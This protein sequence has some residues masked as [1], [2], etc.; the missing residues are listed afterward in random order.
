MYNDRGPADVRRV[1]TGKDA[2]L[3]NESGALLATVDTFTAQVNVTNA[4][5]QPLGDTQSHENLSSYSVSLNITQC[6]IE[7]DEFIQDMFTM[8]SV[9]Q[10]VM[11]TFQ[12]V[13]KGRNGSEQRMI[14]LKKIS[15]SRKGKIIFSFRVHPLKD[16]ELVKCRRQNLKNRGKRNEELNSSRYASQV[17]YMATLDEDRAKIWDNKGALDKLNV[18]SG[19]DVVNAVLKSGEKLRVLEIINELSGYGDELDDFIKKNTNTQN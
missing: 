15:I 8:F 1:F 11:W 13:L 18:A 9:G 10:P 7:D 12:G 16:D 17:I 5:Y 3:F 19:V 6:I 4:T 2:L 14:C